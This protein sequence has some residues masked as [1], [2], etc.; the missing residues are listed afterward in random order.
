[1]RF[2]RRRVRPLVPS[3][4]ALL[5]TGFGPFVEKCG[6]LF[7]TGFGHRLRLMWLLLETGGLAI[8]RVRRLR[9]DGEAVK[10]LRTM[11]LRLRLG[12]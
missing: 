11:Y 3:D 2:V 1:M 8:G 10:I 4:V 12:V 6:V 5:E 7:D 9:P